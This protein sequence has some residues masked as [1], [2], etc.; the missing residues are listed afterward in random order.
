[1]DLE[2]VRLVADPADEY[3][4]EPDPVANYNE[5]MYLNAFDHE[6][7]FGGWFRLGNRVNEGYAEMSCCVHLPDGRIAFMFDRPAITTHEAIDAGGGRPPRWGRW[8]GRG[9]PRRSPGEK[10]QGVGW[11]RPG[12]VPTLVGGRRGRPAPGE[13]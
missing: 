13:C 5:S 12:E 3:N 4:H 6:G 8:A 9:G 7:G 1:M 11:Q 10:F 2:D